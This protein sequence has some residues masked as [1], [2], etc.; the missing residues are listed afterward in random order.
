[1]RQLNSL[2][3]NPSV[4]FSIVMHQLTLIVA[5]FTS[6][7]QKDRPGFDSWRNVLFYTAGVTS[8]PQGPSRS[9]AGLFWS[10]NNISMISVCTLTNI[11]NNT[12][13]FQGKSSKV[14][15]SEVCIKLVPFGLIGNQKVVL[16]FKI[17]GHPLFYSNV[18]SHKTVRGET[19]SLFTSCEGENDLI[20]FS[21]LWNI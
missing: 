13:I 12:K 2:P 3:V 11:I 17:V 21:T 18:F 16:R 20:N 1:M 10:K 14:F 5:H 9:P 6:P 8:R 7:E 19:N 15:I 4:T